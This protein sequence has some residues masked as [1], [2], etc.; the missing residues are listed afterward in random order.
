[1]GKREMGKRRLK[2]YLSQEGDKVSGNPAPKVE[3]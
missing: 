2:G 1:M 3:V